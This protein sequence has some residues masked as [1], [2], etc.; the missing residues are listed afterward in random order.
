MKSEIEIINKIIISLI[1]NKMEEI[2][3][4]MNNMTDGWKAR[5]DEIPRLDGWCMCIDLS[6][7]C[8]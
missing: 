2:E 6:R 4:R 8:I 3:N 5:L 1:N 7:I